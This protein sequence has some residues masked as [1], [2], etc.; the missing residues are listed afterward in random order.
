MT[1]I[2]HYGRPD[3]FI[4]FTCNPSWK[5][6][7]AELF[8][9]LPKPLRSE[10]NLLPTALLRET[11]YDTDALANFVLETEPKLLP[12]QRHV[13]TIVTYHVCHRKGGFFLDAPRGTGKTFLTK[14]ILAKV[15]MQKSIAVA[16]ASS[17]TAATLLP[18]SR[19]AHSTFKLPLNLTKPETPTCNISK[20]S[21]QGQVLKCCQLI[22]WDKCTMAYKGA[23]NALNRPFRISGVAKPPWEVLCF[24]FQVTLGKFFLLSPKARKQMRFKHALSHLCSG[25]VRLLTLTINMRARLLSDQKLAN[26][27]SDILK[28]GDGKVPLESDGEMDIHTFSITVS[29]VPELTDKVFPHLKDNYLNHEWLS[30]RAELP[31]KNVTVT[32]L[33]DQLLLSLPGAPFTYKSVDTMVDANESVNFPTEFLNSLDPLG[34]PPHLLCLKAGTPVMFL[35][36]L[37]PPPDCAMEHVWL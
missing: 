11:P 24:C 32:K 21:D 3:F 30:K 37:E 16:V 31:P 13:Y 4:T 14:L 2:R 6:I 33:N 7:E 5:E 9:G 22:V 12:D 27:A 29:S 34:L 8:P 17:G 10:S 20:N 36:N 1:Y 26:F 28:L 23:F 25:H 15:W 18:G 35:C 19:T